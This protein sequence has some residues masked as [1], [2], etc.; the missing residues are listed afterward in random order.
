MKINFKSYFGYN[1]K[2]C[3]KLYSDIINAI[4]SHHF[5]R[6]ANEFV[7]EYNQ[8]E[9]FK[10]GDV[11]L[12]PAGLLLRKS[13]TNLIPWSDVD[14]R[15]YATYFSIFSKNDPVNINR[16]FNYH[17]DWNTEILKR[18]VGYIIQR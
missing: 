6:L 5:Y 10:I 11:V 14:T 8:G 2:A 13:D 1:K 18:V 4:W 15:D 16:G 9:T 3:N 7:A 12:A 17:Q